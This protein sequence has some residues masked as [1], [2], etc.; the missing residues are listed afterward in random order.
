MVGPKP[1]P[2]RPKSAKTV[3]EKPAEGKLAKKSKKPVAKVVEAKPAVSKKAAV[4]AIKDAPVKKDKVKKI[5]KTEKIVEIKQEQIVEG[6]K[7]FKK[8]LEL[9]SGEDANK[10]LFAS[11]GKKINLQIS[12]IK[13]PRETEKQVIKVKL[14]HVPL[15]E[16]RDVCL[17]VKDLEK[18]L[19]VDHEDSVRHFTDLLEEKGV[20]GVTQ[21][22]SLRELKVEYKQFEAK[23]QLCNK[24]DLFLADARIIRLLPQFLGKHF[25]KR[26]KLP[27]QIDLSSRDLAAEFQ[28]CIST[29][30][31]AMTHTGSTSMV[32]I[33]TSNHSSSQL[34]DNIKTV[35]DNLVTK[36][37]G[38]W[39]NIRS[40]FINCGS[41]S[42]PL[43]ASIRSNNDVGFVSGRKTKSRGVVTGELST[44]VG[45]EVTVTP[46][47]NVRVKRKADPN[48]TE[49]DETLEK[50]PKDSDKVDDDD[51]EEVDKKESEVNDDAK[52]KKSKKKEVQ[53]KDD[54]DDSEDDMEDQELEYMKKVAEEEEEMERKLE[55]N[56]DKLEQTL[57]KDSKDAENSE[58]DEREEEDEEDDEDDNEDVDDAAEAINLL[59][60]NDDS[61]SDEDEI[62][63][64]KSLKEIDEEI[65]ADPPQKQSKKKSEKK[66]KVKADKKSLKELNKP[67]KA[68]KSKDKKQQKFIEK[69]KK[70]KV[71]SKGKK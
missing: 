7:A 66:K 44:V 9:N 71:K 14:P 55:E 53:K 16:N 34:I 63:M 26:K 65:E 23:L 41:N 12:G 6:V 67:A 3:F 29:T 18:G 39:K 36:Y 64:R 48:W 62:M 45:A 19:K 33:G 25:Y 43:Y 35:T 37:P 57:H 20:K 49:D 52:E 69:K 30:Q 17:F 24:F 1:K 38:G 13:I 46:F 22:I 42:L 2:V 4:P 15:P 28:K 51:A 10:D 31:L 60:D 47:G 54:D 68:L 56:E 61:D 32:N 27:L 59:S 21:V 70:E 40:I 5:E 11:E 50:L 58:D 8:L